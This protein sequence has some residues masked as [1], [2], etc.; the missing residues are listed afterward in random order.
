MAQPHKSNRHS[1]SQR[2]KA[3]VKRTPKAA[4]HQDSLT[5][6][7]SE[8]TLDQSPLDTNEGS[9]Y[10]E[11]RDAYA[12]K[13]PIHQTASLQLIPI[14]IRIWLQNWWVITLLLV[15]PG[16]MI[17]V[18]L[19]VSGA[20]DPKH[21]SPQTIY[22]LLLIVAGFAWTFL[23]MPAA[24]YL[25]AS[26]AHGEQPNLASCYRKGYRQFWRLVGLL[27]LTSTLAI[28]GL[29][30]FVVP[31]LITIRRYILSPFYLFESSFDGSAKPVTIREAM[32]RSAADSKANSKN[33]WSVVIVFMLLSG[34]LYLL[35]GVTFK[36]Y[37]SFLSNALA[38]MFGFL[39]VLRYREVGMR[40]PA[41]TLFENDTDD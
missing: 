3:G 26:V 28:G 7:S 11:R 14:S 36:P 2:K 17:T 25:Q 13:Q 39:L 15:L 23:N 31:G 34:S 32:T 10:V 22:G 24:Y 16:L 8:I 37:G 19:A 5:A 1:K 18:G 38:T 9:F 35:I 30:L 21:I 20:I 6:G 40:Q 33:I 27:A 4:V 12:P 29:L 41:K